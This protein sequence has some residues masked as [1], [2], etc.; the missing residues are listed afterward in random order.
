[1]IQLT[2]G[3]NTLDI[4]LSDFSGASDELV[5][6]GQFTD[7]GPNTVN[8][9]SFNETAA[10]NLLNPNFNDIGSELVTNGD[11]SAV[12]LGSEL[13]LDG[14]FPSPN[15][16]WSNETGW[17][18]G[19][20]V[21]S[22]NG[23]SA[24]N[25]ISQNRGVIIAGK[26]YR[27]SF[28]VSNYQ[29]GT[30]VGA[31]SSGSLTGNTPDITANGAYSFDIVSTGVLCIFRSTSS[32]L[33]SI[34]NVSVK[35]V[36]NIV[37]NGDF[38]EIGTQLV[39]NGDFSG[40]TEYVGTWSTI[41][42]GWTL[43]GSNLI[44]SSGTTENLQ[45]IFATAVSRT[46]R[47][48]YEITN[49]SSG[50][51]AMLM[52]GESKTFES[53]NGIYTRIITTTS[54]I[55]EID[56]RDSDPFT[57]TI[58]NISVKELGEGWT[59]TNAVLSFAN[60]QMT[61]DDSGDAGDD[62][63]GTQII[64]TEVGKIYNLSY[65]R[66]STTGFFYLA[67][68]SNDT[69]S[70]GYKNIFYENLGASTGVYTLQFT[71]LSTTTYIGL[72]TSGI[73]ASV[74]S[75]VSVK[76]VGQNWTPSTSLDG[77]IQFT[78]Q[79]LKISNG[80]SNGQAKVTQPSIFENGKTYKFKYKIVA[81]NGGDIGLAGESSAM[82][83]IPGDH[84][85]YLTRSGDTTDFVLGKANDNTDVTVTNISV[86]ELGTDWTLQDGWSIGEDKAVCDGSQTAQS[87]L[88]QL[89]IVPKF[90][91]YKVVFDIVVDAGSMIVAVGGSNAQPTI[92]STNTYTY[93]TQATQGDPNLYF[94]AQTNFVGSVTNVTA[95]EVGQN[96]T[97]Q[98]PAGQLVTFP[99]STL[100][101]EYDSTQ[102]QGS[103]GVYQDILTI[104][105]NYKIV[106]SVILVTGTFKI[107]VGSKQKDITTSGI[108]EFYTEAESD[109]LFI[110]RR[111]NSLS[112]TAVVDTVSVTELDP[113]S[114]WNIP[115]PATTQIATN[116][117][118]I[119]NGIGAVITQSGTESSQYFRMQFTVLDYVSGGVKGFV[120]NNLASSYAESDG[121]KIQYI[122]GG[123]NG[124]L[125]ALF[126]NAFTGNVTNIQLN[127]LDP[128]S[129]W[130]PYTV[131]ASKVVFKFAEVDLEISALGDDVGI[132]QTG[133]IKPKKIYII[134]ISM[135]ATAALNVEIATSTLSVISEVIATQAITTSFVE[136]S[137][138]FI[139]TSTTTKDFLIHRSLGSG[140]GETISI[141]SVS[142][143]S[144]DE[145][146]WI[147]DPAWNPFATT[148]TFV[149]TLTDESTNNSKQFTLDTS[150]TD[151]GFDGRSLHGQVVVNDT[152]A[153][154][155]NAGIIF[156][157]Q[158]EFLEGFYS[159]EI[160]GYLGTY[161]RVL[162]K[163]MAHLQRA[164]GEDGYNRFESYNDKVTYKAYEE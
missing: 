91:S 2:K 99:N 7:I 126:C 101:I 97:V 67:V 65:N 8:N 153:E 123:G 124:T 109:R 9:G 134:S 86:Q 27:L 4:N 121:V 83:R 100:K 145:S 53:A 106:L 49:Y 162:G 3:T 158:P 110:V 118:E 24:N 146:Q 71:A 28:T 119:T 125:F 128:N 1:M 104:G 116:K 55:L 29:S 34:G 160:R 30:L 54:Q 87:S 81:Y 64:T 40:V 117:V 20:N 96:W 66:I 144:V 25:A 75:D 88:F 35:E 94:S 164:L 70:D 58:T 156:L 45:T 32:F 26:T 122:Q 15:E 33:G 22:Y 39:T 136:Y 61:V 10:V 92:T 21:A 80:A 69:D 31:L 47:L 135:K 137:F 163:G 52:D 138:E 37:T 112:V 48:S 95:K 140:N 6:N 129:R 161:Y 43:S 76:E 93:Y 72:I 113:N 12:P 150:I 154:A 132:I 159:V 141:N 114:Y 103:T 107:Q 149:P 89:G 16:R 63:R 41:G 151:G 5:Q 143:N 127:L 133:I 131:A 19:S 50:Q 56:G 13:I 59:A 42:T 60:S 115:D 78:A 82:S 102:T 148:L 139:P 111:Q 108:H 46:L 17:S 38:S 77:N 157:K 147:N 120:S 155:P 152:Q 142:I 23:T 36:L 11:F 90:K 62:S 74:Y 79:G 44:G 130:I 14:N 57:G 98:Q 105:K 84:V 18:I 85:E 73:S 51:V 68:G